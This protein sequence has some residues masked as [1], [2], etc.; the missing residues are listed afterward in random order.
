MINLNPGNSEVKKI[1][2]IILFT[3]L[4]TYAFPQNRIGK[5]ELTL[6]L[7]FIWNKYEVTNLI[8]P[9]R[10]INGSGWSKG[11][12]FTLSKNVGKDFFLCGGVGLYNQFFFLHR[13]FDYTSPTF[14]LFT[15]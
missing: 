7:P 13:P 11:I 6:S 14:P 15:T 4:T 12:D 9:T 10:L 5:T 1:L 2:F 8:G 3:T